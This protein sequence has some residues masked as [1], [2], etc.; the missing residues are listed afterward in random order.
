VWSARQAEGEQPERD[1]IVSD[2]FRADNLECY[3]SKWIECPYLN[4]FAKDSVIFDDAYPEGMPT[5]PIRR[6]LM[7]GRRILPFHYCAERAG[8]TARLCTSLQRGRDA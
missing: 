3:G 8:A 5:I 4:A 7:T 2:T 6:T 1:L